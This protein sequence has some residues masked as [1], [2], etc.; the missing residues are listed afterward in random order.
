MRKPDTLFSE[1]NALFPMPKYRY[2]DSEE[3]RY[4]ARKSN[5]PQK[6]ERPSLLSERVKHIFPVG[7]TKTAEEIA[8]FIHDGLPS[9][10]NY[11]DRWMSTVSSWEPML[12]SID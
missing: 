5:Q 11:L 2:G 7:Y 3:E 9:V 6:R 8:S 12:L 10:L 1:E 4:E